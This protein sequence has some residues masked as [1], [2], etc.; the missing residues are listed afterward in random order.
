MDGVA[1]DVGQQRA[2][3]KAL[4]GAVRDP[5]LLP[6]QVA[7]R[8]VVAPETVQHRGREAHDGA[9]AGVVGRRRAGEGVARATEG[10]Q[11]ALR[12]DADVEAGA[13]AGVGALAPPGDEAGHEVARVEAVPLDEALGQRQR[14]G[15]VVGP[16]PRLEVE[17]TA[18]RHLGVVGLAVSGGELQ[19]GAERVADGEAQEGAA[20]AV[21]LIR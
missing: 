19:G 17:G 18:A 14:H 15:R 8:G 7:S 9:V 12:R 6:R 1:Q 21:V 10:G 3:G 2:G 20:D 4:G 11:G 16:L 13:G 5:S